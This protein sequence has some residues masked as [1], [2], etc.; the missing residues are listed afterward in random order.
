MSKIDVPPFDV[1]AKWQAA[2]PPTHP[3]SGW[4]LRLMIARDDLEYELRNL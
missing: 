4:L 1:A 2:F 3:D